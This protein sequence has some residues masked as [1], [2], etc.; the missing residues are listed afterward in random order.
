MAQL[1]DLNVSPYYDDFSKDKD[2][3]RILFRPGFAVQ[4]RELTTL[5]SIL[6]NQIEQ[7][8]NHMFKEGTVVIPGQLS[9]MMNFQTLQLNGT[10]ANETINPSSFYN[11]TNN[12]V[13][14]GQ[15][16]GVTA[17]IV[18]FQIATSTTQPML[19]VQYVNTGTDGTTQRFA[20]GENLTAN[21]GITHTTTYAANN[22]SAT[23]YSPIDNTTAS[24]SG[25]AVELQE[26]V[27]YIRGQFVRCAPQRLVLSTNTTTVTARVGFT[28][29]ETL[30]TPE[31]DTSLTDNATG[32]SNY[33]AK[34]A[35]RLKITLTLATKSTTAT[36]D[37]NN[38]ASGNPQTAFVSERQPLDTS[39]LSSFTAF[40]SVS[41]ANVQSWVETALGADKV[42]ELKASLDAQIAEQVTPTSVQ[43]IIG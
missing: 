26:G 32:S 27:Y 28:I 20:N 37:T 7:H 33:A 29:T 43:K 22:A 19:Y 14:T 15:T 13:V 6:Q 41:K 8:G 5:Q 30:Q 16:S 31:T 36:D 35:H 21:A 12:V 24:Q 40:A 39:D 23:V 34:G 3:H 38:D 10:F 4:A 42:T 11:A 18:G 2:F 9:F 17:K 25:T 1:T